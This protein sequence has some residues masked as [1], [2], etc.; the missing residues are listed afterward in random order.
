MSANGFSRKQYLF[1]NRCHDQ[2]HCLDW[3]NG[4]REQG[5]THG[6]NGR[7]NS[8]P[9]EE[10]KVEPRRLITPPTKSRSRARTRTKRRRR[11]RERQRK[12]KSTRGSKR[13]AKKPAYPFKRVCKCSGAGATNIWTGR[14]IQGQVG[15]VRYVRQDKTGTRGESSAAWGA[16]DRV[17]KSKNKRVAGRRIF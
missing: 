11:Q 15:N 8:I 16:A 13:W 6:I 4:W 14:L 12:S 5:A 3:V 1:R 17:D 10:K 2:T 9:G 7:I